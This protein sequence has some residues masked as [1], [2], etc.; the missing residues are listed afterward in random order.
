MEKTEGNN[1][2]KKKSDESHHHK[3]WDGKIPFFI[4]L[5]FVFPPDVMGEVEKMKELAPHHHHFREC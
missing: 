5:L 1:Q 3:N 2:A 4:F